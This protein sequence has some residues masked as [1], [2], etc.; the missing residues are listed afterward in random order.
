[1]AGMEEVFQQLMDIS[2]SMGELKAG[3]EKL[4]GEVA[5]VSQRLETISGDSTDV[6]DRLEAMEDWIKSHPTYCLY[7]RAKQADKQRSDDRSFDLKKVVLV[8][9]LA[10]FVGLGQWRLIAKFE[11][12]FDAKIKESQKTSQP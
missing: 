12:R 11:E 1:M 4:R 10:L 3:Q 6:E 7:A 5:L 9:I 8:A 2:G